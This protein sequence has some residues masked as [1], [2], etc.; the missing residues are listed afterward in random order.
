MNGIL[1]VIDVLGKMLAQR[2]QQ[3]AELVQKLEE[4]KTGELND[5]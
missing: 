1:L 4:L 2:D 3:I 5:A